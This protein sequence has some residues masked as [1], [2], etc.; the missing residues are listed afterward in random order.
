MH[1]RGIYMSDNPTFCKSYG[2]CLILCKVLTS[3]LES[4][5]SLSIN[6][7]VFGKIVKNN[8]FN[9]YVIDQI[10]QIL[11]YCIIELRSNVEK[12]IL[13]VTQHDQHLWF[14]HQQQQYRRLLLHSLICLYQISEDCSFPKCNEMKPLLLHMRS[15][16][17]KSKCSYK[18]CYPSWTVIEHWRHCQ[19][20]VCKTCEP[21]RHQLETQQ[22]EAC[23]SKTD[24]IKYL[25]SK[26][27]F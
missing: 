15:C 4:T 3:P 14:Q 25:I 20:E 27:L 2:N 5:N 11:P 12:R 1:G 13:Y 22:K 17:L 6:N 10:D 18:D 8:W 21:Y 26:Y 9:I 19:R 7:S 16:N 23:R 24:N